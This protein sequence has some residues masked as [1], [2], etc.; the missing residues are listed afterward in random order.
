MK[1]KKHLKI[2][3]ILKRKGVLL[4]NTNMF[5]NPGDISKENCVL[6]AQNG[7]IELDLNDSIIRFNLPEARNYWIFMDIT[8]IDRLETETDD[9]N[10]TNILYFIRGKR[11]HS[12]S[13][14]DDEL[15]EIYKKLR[16]LGRYD[17]LIKCLG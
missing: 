15:E 9:D 10:I 14:T 8:K 7:D 5:K 4:L 16:E 3:E 6:Y 2:S 11:E 12:M 13:V 17:I 1:N